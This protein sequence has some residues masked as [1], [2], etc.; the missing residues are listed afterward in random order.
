MINLAHIREREGDYFGAIIQYENAALFDHTG[1]RARFFA[2]PSAMTAMTCLTRQCG[3]IGMCLIVIHIT[4]RPFLIW[5]ICCIQVGNYEEAREM[6]ERFLELVPENSEAWNNIGSLYE[7]MGDVDQAQTA[8]K[9]SVDLNPFQKEANLNL[10]RLHYF[11]WKSGACDIGKGD[12]GARLEFCTV[13]RPGK[14]TGG[15]IAG[16]NFK[17]TDN[18]FLHV[19]SFCVIHIL[20]WDN[21]RCGMVRPGMKEVNAREVSGGELKKF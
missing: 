15:K 13:T 11:L 19:P 8:W 12:I 20:R 6:L 1:V 3:S 21:F 14:S 5:V 4:V 18:S 10:A 2:W 9:R 7:E 17:G 16:E